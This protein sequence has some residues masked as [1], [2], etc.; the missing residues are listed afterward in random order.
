MNVN[1]LAEAAARK[2]RADAL[3]EF[4]DA[5]EA[6]NGAVTPEELARAEVELGFR[7]GDP[8]A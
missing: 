5:W 6:E 7:K 1:K 4:L 3:R 2:R 8:T